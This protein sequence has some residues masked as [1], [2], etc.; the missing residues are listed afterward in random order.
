M[1]GTIVSRWISG[2]GDYCSNGNIP[3]PVLRNHLNQV[4]QGDLTDQS[5]LL[6]AHPFGSGGSDQFP[7]QK[8]DPES[9]LKDFG[10]RYY[11]PAMAR[12]TSPDSIMSHTY[13]PQSLNKYAYVRN[14]PIN[15]ADPTGL[16]AV[17]LPPVGQGFNCST[18]FIEYAA[19]FG[20]TIQQLFDSDAGILGMMNYFEQDGSGTASDQAVWA[21]MDWTFLNQWDLSPSDKVWFYGPNSIPE[22]FQQTVTM[23][24]ARSQV[25]TPSGDLKA[26]FTSELLDILTGSPDSSECKGLATALDVAQ[27]TINAHNGRPIPGLLFIPNPVPGALTFG[28]NGATPSHGRDVTQTNIATLVDRG[29]IWRFFGYHYNPPPPRKRPRPPLP[30]KRPSVWGEL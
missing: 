27:G 6:Y 21:A 5:P 15:L 11:N 2:T 14:D 25:F 18:A 10:A 23:G 13:D 7:G 17:T 12:W 28:S 19:Q 26:G 20:E 22:T 30:P 3:Q 29:N 24:Q 16:S 1:N 8:D 9:S 4:V